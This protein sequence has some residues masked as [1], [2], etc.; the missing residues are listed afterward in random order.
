MI[1]KRIA[2]LVSILF[3]VLLQTRGLNGLNQY[4]MNHNDGDN[5]FSRAASTNKTQILREKSTSQHHPPPPFTFAACLI[6]KDGN[7]LL[8]EW[9]AYHYTFLPLRRLIIALDPLSQTSPDWILEAFNSTLAPNLETTLWKDDSFVD[10][11]DSNPSWLKIR[12]LTRNANN[13]SQADLHGAYLLRQG[14]FYHMCMKKLHQE[15]EENNIAHNQT[16][17]LWTILLDL[18]EYLAFN[19]Y[20]GELEGPPRF[21]TTDFNQKIQ[22]D[23]CWQNYEQEVF[24]GRHPRGR[25][26]DFQH[27]TAANFIASGIDPMYT[28][29]DFPCVAFTRTQM[30]GMDDYSDVNGRT[31][32]PP[33]SG[34]ALA[35]NA[36]SV[37][38]T[39]RFRKH[40]RRQTNLKGKS[41]I[42]ATQYPNFR[43]KTMSLNPHRPLG[44]KCLG[45]Y[46]APRRPGRKNVAARIIHANLTFRVNHYVGSPLESTITRGHGRESAI[47]D[48][49]DQISVVENH[50]DESMQG[51]F[52]RFVDEV[53]DQK[54]AFWLTRGLMEKA[55]KEIMDASVRRA[56]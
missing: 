48:R 1:G 31:S 54:T 5:T 24:A 40:G 49:N 7:V 27:Q 10:D 8:P 30:S 12:N 13:A 14:T 16:Q 33:S 35:N 46:K 45:A 29:P 47:Q 6:M 52:G 32:A 41:I 38:S 22:D 44:D 55:T 11:L 17:P 34:G 9:L 53:G 21:C 26:S 37:L 2:V 15:A 4:T 39:F 36:T 3:F 50:T 42:D 43:V 51:W 19:N 23:E 28:T 56:L 20:E 18:D 25:L